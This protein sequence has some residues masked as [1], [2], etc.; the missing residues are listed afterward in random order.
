MPKR[1]SRPNFRTEVWQRHWGEER[2]CRSLEPAGPVFAEWLF[3]PI[4][5]GVV[6]TYRQMEQPARQ[7][8]VTHRKLNKLDKP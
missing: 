2:A 8:N 5:L 7:I 6:E 4:G 3:T 1:R